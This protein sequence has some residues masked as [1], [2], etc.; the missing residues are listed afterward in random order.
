MSLLLT[1]YSADINK[2]F[3]FYNKALRL[4]SFNHIRTKVTNM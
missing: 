4:L 2:C 3:V 1:P